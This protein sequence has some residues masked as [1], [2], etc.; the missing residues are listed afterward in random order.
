MGGLDC[1]GL[2]RIEVVGFCENG[3]EPPGCKKT[4]KL[5]N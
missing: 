4:W 5:L 2:G 1:S 3:N